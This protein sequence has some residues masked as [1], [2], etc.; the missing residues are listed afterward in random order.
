MPEFQFLR[1]EYRG[2]LDDRYRITLPEPLLTAVIEDRERCVLV[3]ERPYSI[4]VWDEDVWNA[5]MESGISLV[6]AKLARSRLRDR[7]D[8]VRQLGRLL[9]SQHER[10]RLDGRGRLRVLESFRDFLG[11]EPGAD[12]VIVPAAVCIE[13]WRPDAWIEYLHQEMPSFRQLLEE[14]A[15]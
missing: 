6:E 4:S 9:A 12:L 14:L 3:K 11:A 15:G 7:L 13:I 10:V 8:Q 5:E 1:R 2:S